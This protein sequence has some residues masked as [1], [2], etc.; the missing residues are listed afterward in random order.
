M[1]KIINYHLCNSYSTRMSYELLKE[2]CTIH[3]PSGNEVAMKE[4]LL[5]YIKKNSK[6]WKTKPRI[7]AGKELQDCIILV[8]GKPRTAMFAHMDSIGFTVRYNKGLVKIGGPRVESGYALVGEDSQG[9]IECKL[10]VEEHTGGP[11]KLSYVAKREIERGTALTFKP[12]WREDKDFVQ[13]CYMDNRLGIYNALKVAET[14]KDGIIC[15]SCWEESC[16]GSVQFLIKYIY[17]KYK[18]LQCLIS[19]ITW[20][21]EGV[22]HGLGCVISMRDS[23]L[24]RRSYVNRV[25]DIAKKA[26]IPY[27]LEVE[28][29]GGSD[30]NIIHSSPYPIDWC[31][32]GA[33]EANVH[34]PDEKVH[35]KDIEG[36]I[37]LYKELM[38]KL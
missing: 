26:K 24:P 27:Q 7:I 37:S 35:K 36:M 12:N 15:F 23:G 2:M 28:S 1:F 11:V 18:I 30:G 38:K 9:P 8:F 10:K 17:E 22:G 31:F 6:N 14:L 19:D 20:I 4:Y 16:G 13:C 29:S 34:T 5:N 32:V 3:A 25:I 21:T 33:P